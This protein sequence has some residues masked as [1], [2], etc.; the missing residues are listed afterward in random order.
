MEGEKVFPKGNP[1]E[2]YVFPSTQAHYCHFIILF[3]KRYQNY[4]LVDSRMDPNDQ[5]FWSLMGFW[6]ELSKCP[7]N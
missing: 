7:S 5:I 1:T 6:R 4:F 3:P 2:A